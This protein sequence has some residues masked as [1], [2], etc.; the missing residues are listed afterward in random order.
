VTEPK[1][2]APGEPRPSGK[3]YPG[4][5]VTVTFDGARCLHAQE[6]VR[7]LP[8][9]FDVRARPWIQPDKA[10]ADSVAA[11]VR[12]C[13]TG[14]L[15]YNRT[16]EP[17]EEGSEPAVVQRT[18]AGRLYLRGRLIVTGADAP[19]AETRAILCGCGTSQ[20]TPYCD[21]SGPCRHE[22]IRSRSSHDEA[23]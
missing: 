4:R 18:S 9:V 16:G 8:R 22:P 17:D 19:V 6:C 20:N 13:P 14:A 7:G 5:R 15:Q 2:D 1:S 12:R 23:E 21:N 10:P 3:P 11:I